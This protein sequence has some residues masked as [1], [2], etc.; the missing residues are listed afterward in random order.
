MNVSTIANGIKARFGAETRHPPKRPGDTLN[1][2]TGAD[3][4]ISSLQRMIRTEG[5][6]KLR[7]PIF[8]MKL[9][10]WNVSLIKRVQQGR[11]VI[12]PL[13][14]TICAIRA[15]RDHRLRRPIAIGSEQKPLQF[16]ASGHRQTSV[17]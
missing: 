14:Q 13:N 10:P 9:N 12:H 2:K 16:K 11:G 7:R 1:H 15:T 4:Q 5:Q 6:L 8:G 3:Q 17:F